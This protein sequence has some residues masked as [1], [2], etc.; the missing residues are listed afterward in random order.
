M[1]NS[2]YGERN[3]YQDPRPIDDEYPTAQRTSM[4]SCHC[5][6]RGGAQG[7]SE[8]WMA[9]Y[10]PIVDRKTGNDDGSCQR[11]AEGARP[12]EPRDGWWKNVA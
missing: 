2:R 6:D 7:L 5:R 9:L 3:N 1:G 10:V 12:P 8:L 4:R 11:R